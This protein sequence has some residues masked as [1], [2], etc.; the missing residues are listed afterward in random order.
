M[1]FSPCDWRSIWCGF[2]CGSCLAYP[3]TYIYIYIWA[4]VLKCVQYERIV[5]PGAVF[6][7]CVYIAHNFIYILWPLLAVWLL[8]LLLL[9]RTNDKTSYCNNNT[10]GESLSIYIFFFLHCSTIYST[11]DNERTNDKTKLY[12]IQRKKKNSN[13][14]ENRISMNSKFWGAQLRWS[15]RR[16]QWRIAPHWRSSLSITDKY[17]LIRDK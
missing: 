16:N 8:L 9:I 12:R 2:P 4:R 10:N 7:I 13:S 3:Y 15:A 17:I 14:S 6:I 11:A 5:A 1:L